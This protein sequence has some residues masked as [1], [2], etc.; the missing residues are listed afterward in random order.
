MNTWK[1]IPLTRANLYPTSKNEMSRII[2]SLNPNKSV[3]PSSMPTKILKLLK[4]E[5]SSHLSDIYIISFSMGILPSVLNTAKRIPSLTTI[6][7][8]QYL[9]YQILKKF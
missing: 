1:K 7:I 9:F 4:D 8:A 5:I 2:S 6:I 3:G